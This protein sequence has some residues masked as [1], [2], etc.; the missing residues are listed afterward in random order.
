MMVCSYHFSSL[1]AGD[2]EL[3]ISILLPVAKQQRKLRQ[4]TVVVGARSRNGLGVG[5]AID[6]TL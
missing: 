1:G 5:V 2:R 4:E 6:A 3:K